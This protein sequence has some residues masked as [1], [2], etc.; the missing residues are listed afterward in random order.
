[1]DEINRKMLMEN[2]IKTFS[3]YEDEFK[4][5]HLIYVDE[6]YWSLKKQNRILLTQREVELQNKKMSAVSFIRFLKEADILPHL[7]NIEHV[8]DILSKVVPVSNPN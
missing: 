8:E 2:A 7:I 3:Q 5:I 4:S 1:M 6:N